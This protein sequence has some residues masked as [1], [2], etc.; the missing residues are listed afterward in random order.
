MK[1]C[2]QQKRLGGEVVDQFCR[3]GQENANRCTNPCQDETC[4][5]SCAP[6][7]RQRAF[8]TSRQECAME[9]VPDPIQQ[10]Q[11]NSEANQQGQP[12]RVRPGVNEQ[13]DDDEKSK[14]TPTAA[15]CV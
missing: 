12:Q 8:A 7:I 9:F 1:P 5:S 6:Q 11:P 2:G 15:V 4:A 10:I 3:G 14:S 13:A